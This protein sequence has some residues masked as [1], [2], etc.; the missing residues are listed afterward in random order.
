ML[1]KKICTLIL[2]LFSVSLVG[3]A[4]KNNEK[5][6]S[7]VD[8]AKTE[9][10]KAY[11]GYED[12]QGK[13]CGKIILPQ[14]IEPIE[15]KKLFCFEKK[16]AEVGD[17]SE[18]SRM[19]FKAF[20]GDDYNESCISESGEDQ[21]SYTSPDGGTANFGRGMPIS[22]FRAGASQAVT[23]NEIVYDPSKD[24]EKVLELNKGS[25]TVE[26]LC[27][28]TD[29]FISKA[30]SPLYQGY[31][32]FPY[33]VRY[34]SSN[35]GFNKTVKVIYAVR[36]NGVMFE[37]TFSPLFDVQDKGY[38]S[39]ITNY[40]PCYVELG[41]DSPENVGYMLNY[42]ARFDPAGA[43]QNEIISLKAAAE[44]LQNELADNL[45]LIFTEVR[46]M[47]CCK[48]TYPN[49]DPNINEDKEAMR[50]KM[51]KE[52]SI[53][54]SEYVPTWCFFLGNPDSVRT[55]IKINAVTGELTID[56]E[57]PL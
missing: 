30:I 45:R 29:S 35:G 43:P 40:S 7:T 15:L 42:L 33:K 32:L 34:I 31:D 52:F 24:S 49:L 56:T 51:E 9:A 44:L 28:M 14:N 55:S 10:S 25:C 5:T 4:L 12:L 53:Q 18:Q 54:R 37:E 21:Y 22:A 50:E 13:D 8:N 1:S 41:C 2:V 11:E 6:L 16:K 46:L 57:G 47:Y 39:V 23:E 3:C 27:K 36:L 19:F 26:E 20:F 17:S 48:D 38:Y